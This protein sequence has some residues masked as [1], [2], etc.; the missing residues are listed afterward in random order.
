MIHS[1]ED[2]LYYLE[3]DR[4]ASYNK[5]KKPRFFGDEVWK[6]QRLLRK[7]EYFKYCKSSL[8]SKP[9]FYF[10]KFQ[11]NE[12]S[13]RLG[14][15]IPTNV[16]GPGL[17][18][19]HRGTIVVN[20]RARIGA[21]CRIHVD[22]NIG[23]GAGRPNE[24]PRIGNNVYIG[25]GVKIFGAV[26]IADGVVIGANAV[27]NKSFTE[28]NISIAGVPARKISDKSSEGLL[29]KGASAEYHAF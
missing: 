29:R 15:T 10:L 19:A 20:S 6:F 5:T 11:F 4:L 14:F 8:L 28:P 22:V 18:I 27:V 3:A 9:Y 7:L 23:V 17:S 16:F 13:V 26:E 2:Y 25:P 24:A 1:K 12:L 21:N